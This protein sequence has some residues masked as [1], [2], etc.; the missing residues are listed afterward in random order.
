MVY[1]NERLTVTSQPHTGR[2]ENS[3]KNID[4]INKSENV[5]LLKKDQN[6]RINVK[7]NSKEQ[8]NS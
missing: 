6:N 5:E 1:Y 8:L 4:K 3:A 7:N 2:N